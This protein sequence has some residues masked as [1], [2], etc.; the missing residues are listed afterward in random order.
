MNYR[1]YGKRRFW[2][3]YHPC[4]RHRRCH[5]VNDVGQDVSEGS[6]P[7]VQSSASHPLVGLCGPLRHAAGA[8][9]VDHALHM[10]F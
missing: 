4:L 8:A 5:R 6:R 3:L 7:S 10:R 2:R 1:Q 9:A